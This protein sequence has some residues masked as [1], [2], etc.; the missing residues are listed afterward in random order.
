LNIAKNANQNITVQDPA[1]NMFKKLLESGLDQ[2]TYKLVA[3]VKC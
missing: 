1:K 3:N 2:R